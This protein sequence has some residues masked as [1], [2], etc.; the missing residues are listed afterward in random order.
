MVNLAVEAAEKQ[1]RN[2]TAPAQ[3]ITHY[4][5]LGSSREM[6]EQ[7]R[8]SHEVKLLEAKR[9]QMQSQARVEEMYDEVLNAL[10]RYSGN[11]DEE[12]GYD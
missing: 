9:E 5:K 10:R 12:V 1:M 11:G 7:E 8:L 3:I 2:G 6:L 4:L